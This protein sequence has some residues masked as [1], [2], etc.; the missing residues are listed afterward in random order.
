MATAQ[1][2]LSHRD[3][4][5]QYIFLEDTIEPV[6]DGMGIECHQVQGMDTLLLDRMIKKK[7]DPYQ[8]QELIELDSE[9]WVY[10]VGEKKE[11]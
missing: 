1:Y 8:C 7:K 5:F 2:V 3:S 6:A 9:W 11:A 4:G 10:F